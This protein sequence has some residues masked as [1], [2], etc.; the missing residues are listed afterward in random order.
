[1]QSG[2]EEIQENFLKA[3]QKIMSQSTSYDVNY[4]VINLLNYGLAF[5]ESTDE[6]FQGKMYRTAK[7]NIGSSFPLLFS[8]LQVMFKIHNEIL[9]HF[10]K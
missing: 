6:A 5:F 10:D 9:R 8:H 2:S 7:R 4:S 1:M 3:Q